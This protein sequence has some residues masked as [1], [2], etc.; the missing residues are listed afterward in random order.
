MK[1]F[2]TWRICSCSVCKQGRRQRDPK[3]SSKS[4]LIAVTPQAAYLFGIIPKLNRFGSVA[5]E[6]ANS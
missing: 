4:H 3:P 2:N 6:L 5:R 1:K